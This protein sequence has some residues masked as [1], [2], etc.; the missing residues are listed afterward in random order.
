MSKRKLFEQKKESKVEAT[1]HETYQLKIVNL[2]QNVLHV[3]VFDDDGAVKY[4]HVRLQGKGC[5]AAPVISSLAV[6]PHLQTLAKQ[7]FI[8]LE[9]V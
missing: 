7:K 4:L 2:T 1:E 3:P 9:K 6:T 8:K 5:E